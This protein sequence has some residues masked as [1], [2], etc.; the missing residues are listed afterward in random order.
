MICS[1]RPSRLP[2]ALTSTRRRTSRK[3]G[4][5]GFCGASSHSRLFLS[6]IPPQSRW[7]PTM[8]AGAAPHAA[9]EGSDTAYIPLWFTARGTHRTTKSVVTTEW[10]VYFEMLRWAR[11]CSN[12][13]KPRLRQSPLADRVSIVRTPGGP[14][15]PCVH[16]ASGHQ[17]RFNFESK[18]CEPKACF[19]RERVLGLHDLAP[20]L[21][22]KVASGGHFWDPGGS[23]GSPRTKNQIY[24]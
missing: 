3:R 22:L 16:R 8:A 9:R 2:P 1:G 6:S 19:P 5:S 20:N 14:S 24:C 17:S 18:L 10:K 11:F 21:V 13:L 12:F 7:L 4:F 23:G 15:F